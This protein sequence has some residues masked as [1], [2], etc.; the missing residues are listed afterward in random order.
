MLVCEF[1]TAGDMRQWLVGLVLSGR[2][3]ATA[4]LREEYERTGEDMPRVGVLSSVV[5]DVGEHVAT[6]RTTRIEEHRFADVPWEFAAAEGEGDRDIEEWR[7][8]HL[9]FWTSAGESVTDE[10]PV[11]CEW[12][13][14]VEVARQ[15][16]ISAADE[17][18]GAH[19]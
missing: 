1:G 12:F 19:G 14:L 17:D 4:S 16:P 11:L 2:K 3:T 6:I 9:R 5:D 10:T 7:A 18:G 15:W 8:G 13:E